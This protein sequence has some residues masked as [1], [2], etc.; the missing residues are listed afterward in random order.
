MNKNSIQGDTNNFLWH[1]CSQMKDYEQF[2][3]LCVTSARGSYL[4]LKDNRH[5][6]DAISSW[7]CKSLG[8][9]H[10]RLKKALISQAENFEH[11]IL[12]NTTNEV[13]SHLCERLTSLTQTLTKVFF[14]SDGSCAI[15][16]AL[17]M[18][19]HARK[20][21]GQFEK[22]HI[23]ALQNSYHGETLFALS[24]SD[25]GIYRHIYE[26]YLQKSS[27]IQN[28]P[29]VFSRQDPLW[30]DC[31]GIWLNIERQLNEYKKNLSV[32]IV[33]PIVQGTGGMRLYSQDFLRRLRD[34]CKKNDVYF[35]ADEIMTGMCRTG[36][37]L[38]CEYAYIEPDFLCL[39]KGLTGG[40]IPMSAVLTTEEVYQLFYADYG[41]GRDFLHSH[42][43]SG[44]ALGAAVALEVLKVLEEE[45][46]LNRTSQLEKKLFNFMHDVYE[47]T[48]K[49]TKPRGIGGIVAVDLLTDNPRGG[50]EVYKRA[51]AQ[52][53]LLRPLGNTLY[54]LPPLNITDKDLMKLRDVTLSCIL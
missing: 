43:Y 13:I 50:Y 19:I 39:G 27:F 40:Y 24:V 11:V 21:R 47:K 15:E 5:I 12:A 1:P 41:I 20:I 14:A 16:I 53:V 31:S 38:A 34:W 54:W 10:P 33:E 52:G 9:A 25:V 36:K 45:E 18:C 44:N 8:H 51:V 4:I 46:I 29:Y 17:K 35:I 22:Q 32:I 42:T 49:V 7:W 23:I 26:P 6:L 37:M 48:K 28:I 3:P 2:K 30:D